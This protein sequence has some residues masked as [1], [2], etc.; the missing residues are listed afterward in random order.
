M[1]IDHAKIAQDCIDA[2]KKLFASAFLVQVQ[3]IVLTAS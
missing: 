2:F 3:N 1:D